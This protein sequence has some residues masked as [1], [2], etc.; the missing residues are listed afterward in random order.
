LEGK[1]K[2]KKRRKTL[3]V[4]QERMRKNMEKVVGNFFSPSFYSGYWKLKSQ[5]IDFDNN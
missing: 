2:Y 5:I 4:R 3:K 1:L